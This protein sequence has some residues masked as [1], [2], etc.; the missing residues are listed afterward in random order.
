MCTKANRT[1]GFLRRNLYQ[2]PRD[3]KEAV[4]RGLGPPILEYDSCVWDPKGVVLQQEI[5]KVQNMA[6][7]FV[8]NNYSFETGSMTGI[9]ENLKWE[10]V[11]RRR[12]DSRL[13]L[14][15]KGLKGAACIPTDDLIP[16]IRRSRN[17]HSLTFRPPLQ[18]LTFTRAHSS[19]KQSEIGMSFQ[20]RSLPLLKKQRMVWLDLPLVR[21]RD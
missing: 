2:C 19:L 17:H 8:T 13:I 16:A 14:L 9:L 21:A 18:E 15:Y 1:L 20:I 12:R 7:R 4:Y 10:S 3:V 6:A 11:K 5:E